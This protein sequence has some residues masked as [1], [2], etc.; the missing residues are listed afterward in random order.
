MLFTRTSLYS[1]LSVIVL[2]CSYQV[3]TMLELYV[4]MEKTLQKQPC[5]AHLGTDPTDHQNPHPLFSP[6]PLDL[7]RAKWTGPLDR[8]AILF[9]LYKV[10]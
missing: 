6:D 4:H 10:V 5:G 2:P 9:S 1:S 7:Q 3:I 8:E